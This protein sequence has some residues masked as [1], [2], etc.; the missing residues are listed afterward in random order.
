MGIPLDE[1]KLRELYARQKL[2]AREVAKIFGCSEH[3]VNY[4]LSAHRITKRSISEAIYVKHNPKGDPFQFKSPRNLEDAKLLG[5]GLGLY[6]GE[7]NKRSKNSVRLGNTNPALIKKFIEFLIKIFNIDKTKLRFGLQI[8]S[9]TSRKNAL[10][11]WLRE[12]KRFNISRQQFFKVIITPSRG[13]GNYRDKSKFG[14]L[15]VYFSNS[16]IKKVIDDML[17]L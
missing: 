12:L 5:L 10:G 15:T 2:S 1:S 6:W 16:K 14:V 9:D 11:F 3:K 8:F 13:I 17:P 4:W 7:G